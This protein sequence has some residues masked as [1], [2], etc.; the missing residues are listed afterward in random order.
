MTTVKARV[1]WV[2]SGDRK[3]SRVLEVVRGRPAVEALTMLRFMPQKGARII[4]KVLKSAI[5]NA[6]TNNK[7]DETKLVVSECYA[8]KGI[9]MKRF[10]PRARGRAFPIKKRTSHVTICLEEK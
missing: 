8:N 5:A 4:E 2:K 3:I 7:M 10:Q 6:K 1:K 9:I